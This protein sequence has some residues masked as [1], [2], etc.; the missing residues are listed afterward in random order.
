MVCA[1]QLVV[2]CVWVRKLKGYC[3]ILGEAVGIIL[4]CMGIVVVFLHFSRLVVNST[5]VRGRNTTLAC[6]P[7]IKSLGESNDRT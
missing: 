7:L 2:G 4:L 3:I 1:T 5:K 6:M